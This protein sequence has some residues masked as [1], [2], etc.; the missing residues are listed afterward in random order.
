[1][2]AR[3]APRTPSTTTS[4]TA[5]SPGAVCTA[6]ETGTP[7]DAAGT[8]AGRGCS[9]TVFDVPGLVTACP[10]GAPALEAVCAR[11]GAAPASATRDTAQ[12][13]ARRMWT[14]CVTA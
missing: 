3:W 6:S 14:A 4:D 8:P 1:M 12:N 9:L 11:D 2:A 5:L 7:S 10:E 13:S